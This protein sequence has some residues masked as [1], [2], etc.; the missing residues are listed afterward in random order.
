[1]LIA[2]FGRKRTDAQHHGR[3]GHLAHVKHAAQPADPDGGASVRNRQQRA[4]DDALQVRVHLRFHHPLYAGDT[5]IASFVLRD[6]GLQACQGAVHAVAWTLTPRIFTQLSA[7]G[8]DMVVFVV[9][10]RWKK[11]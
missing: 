11:N 7:E 6:R 2:V 5:D 3:T 9:L 8:F 1:M 10:R 4:V